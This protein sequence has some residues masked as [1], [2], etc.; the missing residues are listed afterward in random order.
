MFEAPVEQQNK[1]KIYN[2]SMEQRNK[3][4]MFNRFKIY[5]TLNFLGLEQQFEEF[6][7]KYTDLQK[8]LTETQIQYFIKSTLKNLN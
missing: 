5:N 3:Q 4:K 8:Y 7:V 6:F 1:Q 2:A